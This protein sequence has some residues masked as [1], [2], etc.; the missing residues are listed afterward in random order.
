MR[1][2]VLM[3]CCL[4]LP[5]TAP[6]PAMAQFYQAVNRL[7]VVPLNANDFEVIEARGEGARGIW[8]AAADYVT[9]VRGITSGR[10]YVKTPRGRSVSGMGR[11]GVVFTTNA[12]SL[13][14]PPTTSFS[15]SVRDA[16]SGL[17]VVHAL[18]FCKDYLLELRERF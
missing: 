17:S 15:V 3:L 6:A 1:R 13:S 4:T 5:L 12:A 11:I 9:Q 14:T 2:F 10:L 7:Q 18:Q 8:C 16:G